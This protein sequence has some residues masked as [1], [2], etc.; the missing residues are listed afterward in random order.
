M[1]DREPTNRDQLFWT[2]I[3]FHAFSRGGRWAIILVCCCSALIAD[4]QFYILGRVLDDQEKPYSGAVAELRGPDYNSQ[5]ICSELGVFRFENLK[6]GSYELILITNYGIRRKKIELRGS[7]DITMHVPR[8]IE[9]NEISVVATKAGESE[10]VTHNDMSGKEIRQRDFGQ[11]MPY[12]LETSPSV[13]VTSDAGH[14]IGYT[15]M[16]IRGT[17]PT[18]INV[19]LNG[20]PVNDAESHN[21]FWVD[22]PDLASSVTNIQIQRGVGWSQ[23]GAGDLGA[24]VHVNTLSFRHDPYAEVKVGSGSFDSRRLTLAGGSGLLI[25]RFTLDGRASWIRSNGYIDRAKADLFS[26]YGSAGYHHDQT[27]LR[28]IVLHG[29]ELTYQAWNGVPTQ[30]IDDDKLRT[31]NTAG[32][33]RPGAPHANEVDD[34]RQT[35]IQLHHDQALTP[36]ARWKNALYYTRGLGFFEQYK[37]NQLTQNYGLQKF[38]DP[39]D[40]IRQLWLD[41]HLFGLHSTLHFGRPSSRYFILGGGWNRYSGKHFGQVVGTSE[42]IPLTGQPYYENDALK[43][44][45]NIFARTNIRINDNAD[46]TIDLQGRWIRYEFVGFDIEGRPT[47]QLAKHNF[48]NPKLGL[49]WTLSEAAHFYGLTGI[50]HKEPNRDDYVQSSPVSRPDAERLWDTELGIRFEKKKLN[51]QLTGYRMQ[52]KDQLVP[53]GRLNEVGAYTRVNVDNSYRMGAE[54]VAGWKPVEKLWL[55]FQGTFSQNR[56]ETFDEYID[57]WDDG[58]QLFVRHED[59]D[60]A[61][62]PSSILQ[63]QAGLDI[64]QSEKHA[65]RLSLI[66][67][68]IGEQFVDNTSRDA[69]LLEA[70]AVADA[71]VEWNWDNGKLGNFGLKIMVRNLFDHAYESNGWIYRLK[72]DNYNPVPDDPYAAAEAGGLYHL[73]GYY[74]QAGRH[75]FV[76]MSLTF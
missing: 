64:V 36:F 21:V 10:P 58:G 76:Q 75:A 30:Y 23:P 49:K 53:T 27:N 29:D 65:L 55:E 59:T 35:Y 43:K 7:I 71:S 3:P 9:M 61:F 16:R 63:F 69:S 46:A 1:P 50:I 31:F 32:T 5:Q 34:Y 19:T 24:G 6:S 67:R 8:N 40:I 15:G 54:I 51:L 28:L 57:D 47:D 44:D 13:V 52:Y 4:A 73:K 11:D 17:D 42:N 14:G 33:E 26:L 45:G 38:K 39:I 37:A 18:R 74:P 20:I 60:L 2:M 41:N 48:F 62:S 68:H 25:G 66:G 22:L 70:Y 72:S 56:I 12:I